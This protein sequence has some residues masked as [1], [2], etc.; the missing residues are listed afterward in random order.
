[1]VKLNVEKYGG[2]IFSTW[3]DRPLSIAGKIVVREGNKFVSKLVNIDRDLVII[4][5]LAIHFNRN[6]NDINTMLKTIFY[7]CLEI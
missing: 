2:M 3:F 4:P 5:N 1:M 6:I 7:R